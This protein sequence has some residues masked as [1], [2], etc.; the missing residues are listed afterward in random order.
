[1]GI[2]TVAVYSESD[3]DA[4][5]VGIADE[6]VLLGDSIPSESYLNIRKI[7]KAAKD[8]GADAI[9]P[10]YGFLSEN[11][12]FIRACEEAG[13]IF[14]GPNS[15][16]VEVLGSK[17]ASRDMMIKAGVPVVPGLDSV[18]PGDDSVLSDVEAIGY[19]VM[20][21][22]A[23]GGG[24]KGMRRV[25]SPHNLIESIAAASRE[26]EAAFGD[27]T[28]FVE[29][30]IEKP[31][32]IEIQ[33]ITDKHGNAVHLFERECSIQRRHQKIIEEAPSAVLTEDKRIEMGD[34]AIKAVKSVGYDSI[35]TVEFLFTPSGEYYFLEVNTR[36]QVEH[37]VTE[38]ITGIDIIEKQINIAEGEFLDITQ[39]DILKKGH[40]IEC[41][42]YAEDGDN[43]FMPSSGVIKKL[44]IPEQS[45]VRFDTGIKEGDVIGT[46]YDPIM[47]KLI[48]WGE[49]RRQAIERMKEALIDLA[50]FGVKTSIGFMYRAINHEK[51]YEGDFSTNFIDEYKSELVLNEN[52]SR[53]AASAL[54]AYLEYQ[55]N[56]KE[57]INTISNE[58]WEVINDF[59]I[60]RI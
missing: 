13:L 30:F 58:A 38:E 9:H 6:A 26:A 1:M 35:G 12:E 19:P 36:V 53:D 5:H 44:C 56:Q 7:I 57:S 16:A 23:S 20:V 11:P 34:A 31:R 47:A 8:S 24:G 37:P 21:K 54:A 40:S 45:Y 4:L 18:K 14:V 49:D 15:K 33:V 41:R 48:V 22:A 28:V 52:S 50:V 10:G 2:A 43:N 17:T 59:Q 55:R 39:Q 29:K 46:F 3:S 51:F 27:A 60:G 25:D 42:I 32:H